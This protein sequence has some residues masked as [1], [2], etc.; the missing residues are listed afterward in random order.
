MF[1]TICGLIVIAYLPGAALFRV[2]VLDRDRR[3]SLDAEER[4]F[5][6]I[7]L[8]IA[9]SSTIVLAL[10]A[11]GR[12]TLG[13]L[14]VGDAGLAVCVVLA[15]RGRL[16]YGSSARRPTATAL[17]PLSLVALG[18]WL[19]F[20]PFQDVLG[21]KDPGVYINEGVQIAQRGALV[22]H[23]AAVSSLPAH[24]RDL[25]FPF[26]GNAEYYSNRFMG[27]FLLDAQQ[28]TVVGQFPHL[29]PALIAIA[30]GLDGVRGALSTTPV[31][32]IL[33]LLAVYFAGARLLGRRTALA[34]TALLALNVATV[35]FSREP[36]SE[37]VSQSFI[38]AAALALGRA[39]V[40]GDRFFAP[41]AGVLLGLLLFLRLD[42]PV[43]IGAV[44]V[45]L[46]L[47]LFDRRRPSLLF[48]TPLIVLGAVALAYWH[49]WMQAYVMLPRIV[50]LNMQAS[51]FV[52]L[53]LALLGFCAL[54]VL[55]RF[56]R[57][58]APVRAAAPP[59]LAIAVVVL[60]VY[61]YFFRVQ[62]FGPGGL[63]WSDARSLEI[64]TW[65]FP[66]PALVLALAGLSVV[67][68]RSFWR[69]PVLLVTVVLYCLFVF[70]KI[71]VWPD[72][73]WMARRFIPVILPGASLMAAAGLALIA[74]PPGRARRLRWAGIPVAT[75]LLVL[76]GVQ[77]VRANWPV[78]RHVEYAGAVS[79]LDALASRFGPDDLLVVNPRDET[80]IHV[81][82]LPLNYI[83]NRPAL[84]LA[85]PKPD[86]VLFREFL[87]WASIRYRH[88]YFIGGGG[89]DLVSQSI[90][91]EPVFANR[92]E[93]PEYES[94]RNGYPREV[95]LK[96]FRFGVY[97]FVKPGTATTPF[98]LDVGYLDDLNVYRFNAKELND[99]VPFRWSRDTSYVALP[100]VEQARTLTL[101]LNDGGRPATATPARVTVYLN[102]R[103]LGSVDV[104]RGFNAYTFQ[105]VPDVWAASVT[106]ED[107]VTLK[108]VSTTWN[109]RRA[110]G[111]ADDREL[112]VM[113][114]RVEI[115]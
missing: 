113:V 11:V 48:L 56:N 9:W 7:L 89:T 72:H 84:V 79:R 114:H 35:W 18:C 51:R 92:I 115:R 96:K 57:L 98:T 54:I 21:G 17:L 111:V 106:T 66:L 19:F 42:A 6:G 36:N 33:A 46:V 31:A 12:Y 109:P 83:W 40:D 76:T 30:Y 105:I 71:R 29:Y 2:P 39:H 41:V 88:V 45:A 49:A 3:A 25:F 65:Y 108:L 107:A 75:L 80:D 1:F 15:W 47:Q 95:K 87:Q 5:W 94:R 50:L 26:S 100:H 14:L 20:P 13:G 37:I 102:Q 4:V 16:L 99:G 86:K 93:V 74:A 10:A 68:L 77:L 60:A 64:F 104:A 8:S 81:F 73:F 28:G 34:G 90:A 91:A 103:L 24:L 61:A 52:L 63:T 85:S 23:D 27:F 97:R 53:G 101:W 112:G 69:A 78:A 58:A 44:A 67:T 32:A 38:F 110:L 43:A 22:V 59:M 55:S 70:Y 82:A 62:T